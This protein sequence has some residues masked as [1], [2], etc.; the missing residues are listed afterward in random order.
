MR[1]LSLPLAFFKRDQVVSRVALQGAVEFSDG[2]T[3]DAQSRIRLELTEKTFVCLKPNSR[4]LSQ[5]NTLA[6]LVRNEGPRSVRVGLR[7][8]HGARTFRPTLNDVSTT[9][10][11]E[12]VEPGSQREI[13]FHRECF[14]TYG[15]TTDWSDIRE[16]HVHIALEWGKSDG[17]LTCVRIEGFF[18]EER[19][20]CLGPRL[21]YEGLTKYAA[22][23]ERVQSLCAPHAIG[24]FHARNPGLHVPPP[25]SY[26]IESAQEILAGRIMGQRLSLPFFWDAKPSPELEW[27]HFL[28]RCHFLRT[29]ARHFAETGSDEAAQW[30]DA[31]IRSWIVR[32]PAPVDSNGGAGPAW[33]TLSVAW[34]IRE[35]LWVAGIVW[36]SPLFRTDTRIAV[37][38]SLWESAQSLM[39]YKGH[40]N[41]WL[42]VESGTLALIGLC[43]PEFMEAEQWFATG[44]DRIC[45]EL[46]RQ[47]FPDG[48][49]FELSP[50]YHGICIGVLLDLVNAASFYARS[51]P[52]SVVAVLEKGLDYLAWIMRPDYTWPAIN[53]SG[54]FQGDNCALMK[55]AAHTL[56]KH[57]RRWKAWESD[58][59]RQPR[60]CRTFHD[61]GVTVMRPGNRQHPAYLLFRAGPA[62][63]SHVHRDVLSLEL[64][65]MGRNWLVDP[66]IASY[67]PGESTD[68]YRSA[69]A[70]NTVL[71][72]G[73]EPRP[74]RQHFRERIR[75]GRQNTFSLF[76]E[77]IHI[78]SGMYRGPWEGDAGP[79][80]WVRSIV[81]VKDGEYFIV[82]D[83]LYGTG[84]RV[85][86]TCWQFAPAEATFFEA[87]RRILA[88]DPASGAT[89]TIKPAEPH[90][91]LDVRILQGAKA[92]W[93]GWVSNAGLDIPAPQCRCTMNID[94][95]TVTA[96]LL[97]PGRSTEALDVAFR[98]R[99]HTQA[100]G[101]E[102][103]VCAPNNFT[104]IVT[105]GGHDASPRSDGKWGRHTYVRLTRVRPRSDASEAGS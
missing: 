100:G 39:H 72:D 19:R 90:P 1:D 71:I 42:V 49:H 47:F 45:I 84:C 101:L 60:G 85:V 4:D 26:P 27:D 74:D 16:V 82:V 76:G 11:R 46:E 96:W 79:Y 33:E 18:A 93:A 73:Y 3:R 44:I 99:K 58:S 13:K 41:N 14:G 8:I 34:R 95:P 59:G 94:F 6:L 91:F 69:E 31:V 30:I 35:W 92:P 55:Y 52:G 54:G 2:T 75:S 103:E 15:L 20:I 102:L 86:S 48:V 104:D 61:G 22:T 43:F 78:A 28:H 98:W 36:E 65:A 10:D 38:A 67:A 24:P 23:E 97:M 17:T 57:N 12:I 88:I 29:V 53:D 7:L 81:C 50:L 56:G 21:T 5:F 87:T 70:H 63:A 51:L 105:I 64:H 89:L 40:P 80:T 66:G 32:F 77:D 83:Q 37:L 9:G 62:G 68:Y 25:H